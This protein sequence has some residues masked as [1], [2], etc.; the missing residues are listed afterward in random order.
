M[1]RF[2]IVA[3]AVSGVAALAGAGALVLA[4][5]LPSNAA[6]EQV[7]TV[8][9]SNTTAIT[10][11]PRY[12]DH[13]TLG[14]HSRAVLPKTWKQVV[15]AKWQTRLDD[16]A[17]NRMIRFNTAYSGKIS[18]VTAMNNKI[19]AL[20]GTR[21]LHIV[22]TS[23]LTM[24]S[25]TQQG[26]QTVSTL[27]YTYKSGSQTR[28]V[29]TRYVGQHGSKTAQVEISVAGSTADSKVLGTVINNATLSVTRFG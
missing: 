7:R 29:A 28:W 5:A 14:Y 12:F 17:H 18:T 2:G 6:T 10:Y 20:K 11:V 25:T 26:P 22:G 13:S 3:G 9:A 21:Q 1:K 24:R 23:T 27:V 16:P 8:A 19:K 15:L 4:G